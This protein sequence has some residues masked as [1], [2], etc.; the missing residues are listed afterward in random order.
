[1]N[2]RLDG[3]S[4]RQS[5]FSSTEEAFKARINAGFGYVKTIFALCIGTSVTTYFK[6]LSIIKK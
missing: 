1:M 4:G 5:M 3:I 6:L 2:S